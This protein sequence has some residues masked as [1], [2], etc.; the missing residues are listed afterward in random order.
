LRNEDRAFSLSKVWLRNRTV[1]EHVAVQIS[2]ISSGKGKLLITGGG[3]F[4][5]FLIERIKH[6]STLDVVLPD[7]KIIDFKEALIFAF[8]GVLRIQGKTNCFAS[9]TG[10]SKDS[11]C[12]VI[13]SA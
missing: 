3:A 7:P 6:H 1:Y 4:N 13:F 9:V 8:L 12:G 11:S 2:K 5:S 10:A